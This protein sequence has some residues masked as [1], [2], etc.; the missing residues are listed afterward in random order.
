MGQGV[1]KNN[2][3]AR[4]I[5]LRKSNKWDSTKNILKHETRLWELRN[6]DRE[7]RVYKENME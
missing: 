4:N 7:K 5:V 2:D 1:E 6:H 3:L